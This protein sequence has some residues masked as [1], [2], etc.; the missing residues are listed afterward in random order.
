MKGQYFSFDA[1]IAAVIFIMAF[2]TI[3]AY[4]QA[5][6]YDLESK[7]DLLN[8]EAL[9]ISNSI[10]K[11]KLHMKNYTVNRGDIDNISNLDEYFKSGYNIYLEFYENGN[12][13]HVYGT[14]GKYNVK[15]RRV[16]A[17]NNKG[18]KKLGYMDLYLYTNQ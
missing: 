2:T 14:K 15:I 3:L 6:K 17:I 1:V 10:L 9:S 7:D 13:V 12:L 4:W 18:I 8:K 11:L 16:F 5:I